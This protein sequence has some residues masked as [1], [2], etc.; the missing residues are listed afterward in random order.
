[1]VLLKYND[2]KLL[3]LRMT[4][5]LWYFQHSLHTSL[6]LCWAKKWHEVQSGVLNGSIFHFSCLYSYLE[7]ATPHV[8]LRCHL[9][10]TS[11]DVPYLILSVLWVVFCVERPK[12]DWDVSR[13]W[14]FN[15]LICCW[16]T[17][18][19]YKMLNINHTTSL[20]I[21]QDILGGSN[22]GIK[23]WSVSLRSTGQVQTCIGT[24]PWSDSEWH[25]DLFQLRNVACIWTKFI[26]KG[27]HV[28]N[29][30]NW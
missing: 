17:D 4:L 22:S 13:Q 14:D 12:N 6:K 24:G 15:L 30:A 10:L 16:T 25:T 1:M 5:G 20:I 21:N 9:A 23:W 2:L 29:I 26:Q 7:S 27:L 3:L 19:V 18:L 8:L 11:P 28:Q